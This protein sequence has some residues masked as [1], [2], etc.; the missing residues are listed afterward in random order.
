MSAPETHLAVDK[1]GW[2]LI[3]Q[4]KPV[5]TDGATFIGCMA[6]AARLKLHVSAFVWIATKGRFGSVSEARGTS[7]TRC[8]I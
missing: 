4:G 2:L 7:T 8:V 3:H 1:S 6:A 5:E